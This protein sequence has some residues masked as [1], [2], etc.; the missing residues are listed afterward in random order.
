[1]T[2]HFGRLALAAVLTAAG[3]AVTA[4]AAVA[5]TGAITGIG[6]KCVD[7]P[8]N[9]DGTRVQLWSCTGGSAQQWSAGGAIVA[10]SG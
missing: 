8:G 2:V 9:A 1:M 5:G 7:V 10:A 3:V 6:G 4:P